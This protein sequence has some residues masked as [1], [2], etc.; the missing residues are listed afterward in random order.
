MK[1]AQAAETAAREAA[2]ASAKKIET[3]K[4]AKRIA[5][6]S[7][8]ASEEFYP[9]L[10]GGGAPKPV[11][12]PVAMNF[13]KTVEVMATRAA[14]EEA[15]EQSK[16]HFAL[17]NVNVNVKAKMKV[18]AKAATEISSWDSCYDDYE[19]EEMPYVSDAGDA[20]EE[21]DSE[22][23]ADLGSTRR[24]GDKGIW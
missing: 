10:G 18:T 22:F 12:K 7:N 14:A 4:E 21:S 3:D 24:R 19:S 23:N 9:A 2:A 20:T 16:T 13:K 6:A 1:R 15:A 8:F 17:A 11:V 5:D